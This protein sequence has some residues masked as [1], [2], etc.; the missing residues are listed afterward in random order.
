[1]LIPTRPQGGRLGVGGDG[2]R[3]PA[4]LCGGRNPS[5]APPPQGALTASE[6]GEPQGRAAQ[7][8]LPPHTGNDHTSTAKH[9]QTQRAEACSLGGLSPSN[10]R[11]LDH[12]QEGE[13]RGHGKGDHGEAV[14]ATSQPVPPGRQAWFPVFL[15]RE[16]TESL[17]KHAYEILVCYPILQTG[18]PRHRAVK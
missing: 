14:A 15:N 18:Q 2:H 16:L 6:G 13:E 8:L 9:R 11:S 3:T 12:S 5:P 1:M 4:P 10:P 7:G 17:Q